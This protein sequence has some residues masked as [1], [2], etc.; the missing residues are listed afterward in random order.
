M[1]VS[2]GFL[3]QAL[4]HCFSGKSLIVKVH[5]VFRTA[6]MKGPGG[7]GRVMAVHYLQHS[8]AYK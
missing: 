7:A 2:M 1:S 8:A 5:A 6:L 3:Q 4:R